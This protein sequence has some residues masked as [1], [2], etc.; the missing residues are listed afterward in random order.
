MALVYQNKLEKVWGC[1]HYSYPCIYCL[2]LFTIGFL[3]DVPEKLI[4]ILGS[5]SLAPFVGMLVYLAKNAKPLTDTILQSA[6][7]VGFSEF[8]SVMNDV[9]KELHN[10]IEKKYIQ[11]TKDENDPEKLIKKEQIE[12]CCF[13]R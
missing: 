9:Q 4:A 12:S 8:E 2:A 5:T 3:S 1:F 7:D 13:Y 11:T 10:V 6:K